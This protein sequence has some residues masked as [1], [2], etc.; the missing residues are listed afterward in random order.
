VR[1]AGHAIGFAEDDGAG[2]HFG[3]IHRHH[4][5]AA[6]ADRGFILGLAANK[7]AGNID[8]MDDGQME[9]VG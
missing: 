7:E 9:S 8:Q 6:K 5:A 4:R 3:L 2:R 1:A